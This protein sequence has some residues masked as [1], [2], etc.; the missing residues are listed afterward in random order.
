MS[1]EL[2]DLRFAGMPVTGSLGSDESVEEG[3]PS[4]AAYHM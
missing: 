1:A 2:W 3:V 4:V